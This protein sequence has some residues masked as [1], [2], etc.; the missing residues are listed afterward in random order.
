MRFGLILVA[1]LLLACYGAAV[2]WVV[3]RVLAIDASARFLQALTNR[4]DSLNFDSVSPEL[5]NGIDKQQFEVAST[6][7]R[8]RLLAVGLGR[9]TLNG[10]RLAASPDGRLALEGSVDGQP[11]LMPLTVDFVG[12]ERA[13]V[14]VQAG[15]ESIAS[16]PLEIGLVRDAIMWRVVSLSIE[17][18]AAIEPE[19][20]VR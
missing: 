17:E 18:T 4:Q 2:S 20:T 10:A 11:S 9:V 14:V 8:H 5:R 7:A 6:A 1:L 13:T 19:G 16:I 12:P 3:P 15:G